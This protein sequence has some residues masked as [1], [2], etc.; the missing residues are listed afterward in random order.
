MLIIHSYGPS[1]NFSVYQKTD[2]THFSL[3]PENLKHQSPLTP[4]K[5]KYGIRN[6]EEK[7]HQTILTIMIICLVL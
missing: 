7:K 4:L 1:Q 6:F 5:T 2:C 3:T